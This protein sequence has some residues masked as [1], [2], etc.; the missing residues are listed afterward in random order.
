MTVINRE[1]F[2]EIFDNFD[3]EEVPERRLAV[4]ALEE[5][6]CRMIADI[7]E[8]RVDMNETLFR[9]GLKQRWNKLKSKLESVDDFQNN[10]KLNRKI[11]ILHSLR[12]DVAHNDKESP[13]SSRL[14]DLRDSAKDVEKWI[15]KQAENYLSQ[16][17]DSSEM[18]TI[19][20]RIRTSLNSILNADGTGIDNLDDEIENL[21][22]DAEEHRKRLEEI[23]PIQNLDVNVADLLNE[24]MGMEMDLHFLQLKAREERNK[25]A[26]DY[27]GEYDLKK[28]EI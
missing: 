7:S 18:G 3:L 14:E 24:S 2:L 13:P 17:E 28:R 1:K 20:R 23:S 22:E 26:H 5:Y 16:I 6:Y 8:N 25:D 9:H 21:K 19:E 11:L 15:E 12:N 10:D 4:Y 27:F